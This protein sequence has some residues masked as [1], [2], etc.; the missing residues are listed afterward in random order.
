MSDT[1]LPRIAL[2]GF[3][4]AATAFLTGW[5][6]GGSGRVTAYDIKITT[7]D[8][9]ALQSRASAAGIQVTQTPAE[10]LSPAHLVFSLVT[11][12]QALAAAQS[13]APHLTPGTLWFDCNS[14]APGTKRAAADLIT[15]HGGRYVD[16]AV[17]A[18]VHP[19]LHRTPLLISG[20]HTQAAAAAL[21][22]LD[23]SAT[24]AGDR[25]GEASAIKMM[26]SV[27]IKGIEALTAECILAARAA[28]VETAVLASLQASDPNTDWTARAAYNLERMM[29]HGPRRAAEMREVAATLRELGLPDRMAT[30]TADW[31]D[32][33]GALALAGG[34]PALPDRAD[35]IL[36]ALRPCD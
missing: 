15:A 8:A 4:E 12:D 10:A 20:A 9:T 2:I 14:C 1:N 17:M 18:P 33:I 7:P 22:S 36:A 23:M 21:Q 35:R 28:G 5:A 31:Q 24:I 6:L 25:I 3:G 32:Q 30:A 11:A 27:M 19:R 34:A 29:V 16:V 13:A 26:R